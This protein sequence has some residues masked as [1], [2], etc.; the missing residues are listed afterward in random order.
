MT[1]TTVF[2]DAGETLLHAHP[3]FTDLLASTLAE[4][5]HPLD[6]E[7]VHRRAPVIAAHFSSAAREGDLWTTSATSS[8]RFWHGVYRA[9][10]EDLGLQPGDDLVDLLYATF[11]DLANYRLFDDVLPTLDA[12]R[13]AGVRLGLVSN[14]EEWL[15]ALL[16]ALGIAEYFEVRVVSGIEGLEKPDPRIFLLAMERLGAAPGESAYVGDSPEFD[17]VPS[18]ALGM[19]A[20][21]I[22][23]RDRHEGIAA[24]RIRSLTDLPAT[25]GVGG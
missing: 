19:R 8:R 18:S 15:E 14:F 5:G 3:T 2:F 7:E 24:D 11:T 13:G 25:L 6:P 21:L 20:V 23:R 17:V 12:L 4:A 16:V 1:V 9:V 22:D 10:L